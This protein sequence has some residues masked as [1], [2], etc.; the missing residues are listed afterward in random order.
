MQNV[1]QCAD[2]SNC[3]GA[4]T[5]TG[6]SIKAAEFANCSFSGFQKD[7]TTKLNPDQVISGS[8]IRVRCDW[9][10]DNLKLLGGGVQ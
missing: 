9:K 4:A 10:T 6:I 5:I 3:P 2:P 7:G 8:D 1:F